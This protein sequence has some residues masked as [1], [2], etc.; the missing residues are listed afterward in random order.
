M[1]RRRSA[2]A[3]S[4]ASR[5]CDYAGAG[6]DQLAWVIERLNDDPASRSATITTFEPLR[7]TTYIP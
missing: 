4:Y 6:R 7:D 3:G 1:I 2:G 5:I